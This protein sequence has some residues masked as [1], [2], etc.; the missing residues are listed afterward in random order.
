MM[1]RLF[2]PLIALIL[3]AVL[4]IFVDQLWK[5][6]AL[7][8]LV[9]GQAVPVIKGFFDLNLVFNT[10]AAF[11]ILAGQRLLFLILPL[12]TTLI[13]LIIFVRAQNKAQLLWPLGLLLGGII[14][15]FIDRARFGCVIDFFDLYW[16]NYHWPAFNIADTCI[17]IGVILLFCQMLKKTS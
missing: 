13:V 7:R 5:F 15:N 1:M 3:I 12:V 4:I 16:R 10:G 2:K 14:G 11:G 8:V 9:F 6:M 17:C